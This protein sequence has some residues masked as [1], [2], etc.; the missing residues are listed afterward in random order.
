MKG[1]VSALYNYDDTGRVFGVNGKRRKV[2]DGGERLP[3]ATDGDTE[4]V[5]EVDVYSRR[6][7]DPAAAGK[8]VT[9]VRTADPV[10]S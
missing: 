8:V 1:W 4:S 5:P 7:A 2:D 10:G 3:A 9:L 6:R